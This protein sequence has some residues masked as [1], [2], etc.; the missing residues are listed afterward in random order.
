MSLIYCDFYL[1]RV[2]NTEIFIYGDLTYRIF[3]YGDLIFSVNFNGKYEI[4]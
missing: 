4:K 1:R 3:I 2:L